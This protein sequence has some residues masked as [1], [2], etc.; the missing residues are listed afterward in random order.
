MKKTWS[1]L[2]STARVILKWMV[3]VVIIWIM[4]TL[5]FCLPALNDASLRTMLATLDGAYFMSITYSQVYLMRTT[6]QCWPRF[7][8][9]LFCSISLALIFLL[10]TLFPT[11]TPVILLLTLL[12]GILSTWSLALYTVKEAL[13]RQGLRVCKR[14]TM[15]RR[16]RIVANSADKTT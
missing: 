15:T 9:V 5:F 7:V 6:A 1:F 4:V 8:S 16:L 3:H 11:W 2:S 14:E 10:P 13:Y 12:F